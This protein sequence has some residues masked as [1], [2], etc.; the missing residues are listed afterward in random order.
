MKKVLIFLVGLLIA[1]CG[2]DTDYAFKSPE[3]NGAILLNWCVLGE[4]VIDGK[5]CYVVE[6][7]YTWKVPSKTT[8]KITDDISVVLYEQLFYELEKI[9][10]LH[11]FKLVWT[12][13]LLKTFGRVYPTPSILALLRSIC[14][15]GVAP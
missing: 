3:K 15:L 4:R 5:P 2:G 8:F 11:P 7:D 14:L 1:M 13:C 12:H 6:C 10:L 9:G